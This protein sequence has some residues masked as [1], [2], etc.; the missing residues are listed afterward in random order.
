MRYVSKKMAQKFEK[1]FGNNPKT[2]NSHQ[3]EGHVT[4]DKMPSGGNG[5]KSKVGEYVDYEEVD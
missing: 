2:S 4:I 3:K 5:S 1:A